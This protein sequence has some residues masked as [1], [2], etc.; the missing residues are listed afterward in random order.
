MNYGLKIKAE[1]Y[2][3]AEKISKCIEQ[4]YGCLM[5]KI[6]DR[7]QMIDPLK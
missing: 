3:D 6:E 2:E 7:K 1:R 5:R 4:E